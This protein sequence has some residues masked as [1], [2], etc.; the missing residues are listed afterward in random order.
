M[1]VETYTIPALSGGWNGRDGIDAMPPNAAKR[2]V[3]VYPDNTRVGVRRGF[4]VASEG[5]GTDP[6]ET[7]A[8]L[9]TGTGTVKLVAGGGAAIYDVTSSAAADIT[10]TGL[11]I[12]SNRWATIRVNGILVLVNGADQPQQWDGA[13]AE[14][15]DAVYTGIADDATLVQGCLYRNR[16]YYVPVASQSIWYGGLRAVTGALS[17]FGLSY[18][19]QRGGPLLW[20]TTLSESVNK[21]SSDAIVI[22]S[23][24]GEIL[25]YQ[26]DYP[27]NSFVLTNR[28]LISKPLGR[29][30][31]FHRN[32]ELF[33]VT[34]DG[35]W[36]IPKLLSGSWGDDADK[37]SAIKKHYRD[38]A[39]SYA[40][41]FGWEGV[42]YPTAGYYLIN[43][44]KVPFSGTAGQADQFIVNASTAAAALFTGQAANCWCVS[45]KKLFFGSNTGTVYQADSGTS[46]NT[47]AIEVDI[48]TSYQ[49]LGRPNL[50]KHVQA[51]RPLLQMSSEISLGVI[52][53]ADFEDASISN[54]VEIFGSEGTAWGSAW[55][56]A[57]SASA[58]TVRPWLQVTTIGYAIA[59]RLYAK[60]KYVVLELSGIQVRANTGGEL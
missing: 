7:L 31:Y 18:V 43:V 48:E 23:E 39:K 29:R 34:E 40:D 36:S 12:T 45:D 41:L 50:Q 46:D 16:V 19:L 26:G 13:A 6:I 38:A 3:N 21:S 42:Y 30:S 20:V 37:F 27:G 17:E 10:Q 22:C 9:V 51:I 54:D 44:P 14:T 56:S 55:G 1:A 8:E 47:A 5:A 59:I 49:Y 35:V 11:T 25:V 28:L 57:W 60:I 53:N 15:S 52:A 33:V 4:K 32:N 2:M 24:E 58:R